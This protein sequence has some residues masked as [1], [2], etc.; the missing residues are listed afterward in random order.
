M[1]ITASTFLTLGDNPR[2][3]VPG[4]GSEARLGTLVNAG[5][6]LIVCHSQVRVDREFWQVIATMGSCL[7]GP[8]I[9]KLNP[10]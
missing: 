2:G 1:K 7:P 3:E 8:I 9:Y 10:F 6:L 4:N 5:R